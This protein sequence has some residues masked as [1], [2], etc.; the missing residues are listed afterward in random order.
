[1]TVFEHLHKSF[2]PGTLIIFDEFALWPGFYGNK[3]SEFEALI[4]ASEKYGFKYEYIARG[5]DAGRA[6]CVKISDMLNREEWKEVIDIASKYKLVVLD[7]EWSTK[8]SA[9][10]KAVIKIL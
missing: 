5:W 10:E 2:V 3:E 1:M 9:R 4:D 7:W 8:T 6:D